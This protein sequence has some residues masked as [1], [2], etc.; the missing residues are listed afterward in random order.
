MKKALGHLKLCAQSQFKK[1]EA[2]ELRRLRND[3][4]SNLVEE[5]KNESDMGSDDD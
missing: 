1:E 4:M 5:K 2:A 3:P